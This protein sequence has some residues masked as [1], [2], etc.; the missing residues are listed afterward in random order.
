MS[1]LGRAKT[2]AQN[3][4][5]GAMGKAIAMAPDSWLP[6]GTP[7]PLIEH[8]HGLIGAPVSRIDGPLKVRGEATFAAEFV[9]G[10]MVYAAVAF[11]T[12]AKGR[13][14]MLDTGEAEAAPGVVLV[15]TYRNAPRMAPMPM[16]MG[17]NERA[18][19]GDNL[20]VMQDD[21]IH[22]NG[23][24]VAVVLAETQ[25]QADHAKSLIHLTYEAQAAITNFDAAKADGTSEGMMMGQPLKL[26]VGDAQLRWRAPRSPSMRS[27]RRRTRTT[28]RSSCTRRRCCGTATT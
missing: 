7:D 6:G 8:R 23:Q 9:H 4:L 10:G 12:I 27:T 28:T 2:A 24:P 15:M 20:P 19:G 16:V 14:A 3:V 17:P 1:I 22:W 13:I 11:S 25:E 21:Q 26:D 18:A 5:Q